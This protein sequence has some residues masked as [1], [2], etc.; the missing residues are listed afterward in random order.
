MFIKE[1]KPGL[2]VIDDEKDIGEF[3]SFVATNAGYEV[4][5]I[6]DPLLF[7]ENYCSDTSVIVMDL[8]M[9]DI[10]GVELLRYL[11]S[12]KSMASIIIMSGFDP[13]VLHSA[14]VLADSHGLNIIGVLEKPMSICD[15]EM[16]LGRCKKKTDADDEV[17]VCVSVS[18]EELKQAIQNNEI[19]NYYQPLV[20]M[21]SSFLTSM[22]ALVRWDHPTKGI[23]LPDDF[24]GLAED[25]GLIMEL[26]YKVLDK[27]LED[28]AALKSAGTIIQIAVN[29]SVK[30]LTDLR[31]PDH[32]QAKLIEYNLD[33]SQL[34][35]EVTET[36]FTDDMSHLLDILTRIRMKGIHLS[37][38]DFGTGYSSMQMLHR[39]PFDQLKIDRSFV[40]K[41]TADQGAGVIVESSVIFSQ[42]MKMSV[43]AEGVETVEVWDYL[44]K[45]GCDKAQGYLIGKPI[46]ADLIPS[47]L[48]EWERKQLLACCA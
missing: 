33:P 46:P 4:T 11:A 29:V 28:C 12:V 15:L 32:L 23:I 45:M 18:V 36:A 30:A 43:V 42:K 26:T 34:I 22:E 48:V 40:S 37:I 39:G 10:D 44:L 5:S 7:K 38:D 2:L 41:V 9:P 8:T 3:V 25:S 31:F 35:I 20:D 21:R 47:W 17:N 1:K 27:A 13:G 14:K 16:M 24:V 6:D 19:L